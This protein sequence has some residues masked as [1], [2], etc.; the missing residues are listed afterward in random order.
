M[1][2]ASWLP[3]PARQVRSWVS[4]EDNI[5]TYD[6]TGNS[7]SFDISA[8]GWALI[9]TGESSYYENTGWT[10]DNSVWIQFTGAGQINAGDGLS[11]DGNT[12]NVNA[13][14]GIAI[15]TDRVTVDLDA[16][17]SGLEF[18]GTTPD[19]TLG[20]LANTAAG[21][22]IDASGVKVVLESDGALVFDGVNGGIEVNLETTNPTLD[23]V[24][25]ELGVKYST[26]A[27][28]LDQD[29]N[30]LKVKVD[31][32][33]KTERAP[34]AVSGGDFEIDYATGTVT[35][36]E[37]QTGVVMADYSASASSLFI[38][39]PTEGKRLWM[40]Y[41]EVQ[42]SRDIDIKS[43]TYFQPWAYNPA[44]PPNKVPVAAATTYKTLD[45]Y[46]EEANGC[47]PSIPPMG[48]TRGF[49]Q[50]RETFPFKYATI[51]ELLPSYGLEIRVWLEGDVPFGGEYGTATFYCTSRDE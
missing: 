13:G 27:S 18:T 44:D 9:V 11:K 45:N 22:D 28:G 4:E 50:Y 36:F 32:V 5:G 49:S 31:G 46:I 30:G 41:S 29:A 42:F 19:K 8:E 23:I 17:N 26:T 6:A 21:L 38:I 2:P 39:A 48:G 20:V 16:A 14:D 1:A 51:K 37:A 3:G 35:F 12:L 24:S 47:Y 10:Y 43:N 40:E 33:Q 15:V 34:W 25:N 7:W